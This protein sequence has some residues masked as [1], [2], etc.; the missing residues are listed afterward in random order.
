MSSIRED[1]PTPVSKIALKVIQINLNH[2]A[3][4]QNLLF[5]TVREEKVDVVIIA[6]QYRNLDGLF[7]KTDAA[8]SAVIRACGKHPVQEVM[9]NPEEAFVRVKISGI[10]F[11]SCYMPPSMPHEDFEKITRNRSLVAIAGDFNAW[12]VEWGSKET[13]KK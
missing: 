8:N 4:A 13:K 7:W 10:Y 3:A 11:D 6:D 12:T 1:I 9:K 5:Q 2:C